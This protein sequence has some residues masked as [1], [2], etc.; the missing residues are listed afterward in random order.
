MSV[1]A[2]GPWRVACVVAVAAVLAARPAAAERR[3]VLIVDG[4][5][6]AAGGEVVRAL[7]A[8]LARED[9]LGPIAF[10]VA[11]ALRRPVVPPETWPAEAEAALADARALLGRFGYREAADRVHGALDRLAVAAEHPAARKRLAELALLEGEALVGA[12]DVERAAIA[13]RL[14]HRL[15][16]GRTIDPA[17][18]LPEVV[19]A[20]VAA[21]R[22]LPATGELHLSAP[23]ATELLVDGAVVGGEPRVLAIAPGPHLV[24]ARGEGIVSVGR[25]I[26]V[27]DGQAVRVDLVPRVAPLP[28]QVTRVT[29]RLR[30]A[31]GDVALADAIA[32]LLALAQAADAVVVVHGERGLATRLFTGSGGLRPTR[33]FVDPARTLAPLRPLVIAPIGPPPP[34]PVPPEPWYRQRWGKTT[35]G[36]GVAA[37]LAGV[38][39]AMI[40]RDPGTS[41]LTGPPVV[42]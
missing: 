40:V 15:D 32:S 7:E 16:P 42:D 22:S 28:V 4:T 17:R 26:D 41:T 19:T 36:V 8:Q 24:A 31:T 35:I 23:G 29:A 25:R 38:V 39:T 34:P 11:D 18:Y 10:D 33:R 3:P 30:A 37:V 13:M 5:A 27:P 2:A 6:D 21:G 14:V 1:R 20:F 9:A 12:G